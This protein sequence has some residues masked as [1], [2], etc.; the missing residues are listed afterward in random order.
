MNLKTFVLIVILGILAFV[1]ACAI[2]DYSTTPLVIQLKTPAE[3]PRIETPPLD[4]MKLIGM[5]EDEA[6]CMLHNI[7]YKGHI[8][9]PSPPHSCT[10]TIKN[11]QVKLAVVNDRI[12]GVSIGDMNWE[13]KQ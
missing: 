13:P 3:V 8:D 5:H 2:L 10:W 7:A 9:N 11:I 1:A 6:E 4:Y 12:I